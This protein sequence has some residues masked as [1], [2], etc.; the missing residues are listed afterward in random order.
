MKPSFDFTLARDSELP[1][2]AQLGRK[3]RSLIEEGR[4][5][6]GGRLPS[7]RKLA[8]LAGV[9]VNTVR[10]VYGRLEEQGVVASEQGRGTFVAA[11]APAAAREKAE[12][13]ASPDRA[14]LRREIERLEAEVA[15]RPQPPSAPDSAVFA[16]SKGAAS[17]GGGLLSAGELQQVRDSLLERLDEIENA[18]SEVIRTLE[19]LDEAER[20]EAIVTAEAVPNSTDVEPERAPTSRSAST[21]GPVRV[22]WV[23]GA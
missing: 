15:R 22:R 4:L 13:D 19:R 8:D 16:Q 17:A 10:A 23:G 9:N 2:G 20:A 7:V 11:S 14:A 18:R 1:L 3:I 21:L 6:P 12:Q 5:E